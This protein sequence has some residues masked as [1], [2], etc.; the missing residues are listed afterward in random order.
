MYDTAIIGGGASGLAAAIFLARSGK[1]VLLLERLPRVGK[2]LLSTGNGRCNITNQDASPCH[3]HSRTPDFPRYALS[4]FPLPKT[5]SFF[6]SIGLSIC[7]GEGGRLYPKSLQAGSVLDLLR[8]ELSRL[9]VTETVDTFVTAIHKKGDAFF[10][11]SEDGKS[12]SAKSVLLATGGKA[13]PSMGT[14]GTGYRLAQC[15]GH[16]LTPT[17]P[18][19]VQLK[20]ASPMRALKGVK[21]ICAATIWVNGTA[22]KTEHGEVLFTDYGL[23]GPPI[24]NL[25]R[26]ASLALS[27]KKQVAITLNLFP[28]MAT[29]SLS[30]MLAERKNALPHLTGESFLYGLLPKLLGREA[31]KRADSLSALVRLLSAFPFSVTGVMPWANAQCTIGGVSTAEVDAETMESRLIENLYFCGELLDVD[32]DCGGFNLQWAWSSAFVAAE[33]IIRSV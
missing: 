28:D 6:E 1:S 31:S 5:L 14:D 18:S 15:F 7:A 12:Y 10:V 3:Y 21:H 19:L 17:L 27:E 20:T 24:F 32:G 16:T 25:S 9:G 26:I 29:D 30:R 22:E 11:T 13:A 2:K 33:S 4:A 23:S 8:L